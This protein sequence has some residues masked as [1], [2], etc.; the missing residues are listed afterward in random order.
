M[1][2]SPNYCFQLFTL[3]NFENG[4]YINVDYILCYW[5]NEARAIH[6]IISCY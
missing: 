6:Y 3:H 1:V 5:I 4:D 2:H